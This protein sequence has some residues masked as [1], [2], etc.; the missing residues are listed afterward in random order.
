[1]A[2]GLCGQY[3]E[4]S[5]LG[6]G[7]HGHGVLKDRGNQPDCGRAFGSGFFSNWQDTTP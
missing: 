2:G 3:V 6:M 1:L 7:T 5:P 4:I